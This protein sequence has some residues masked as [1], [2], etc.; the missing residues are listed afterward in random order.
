MLKEVAKYYRALNNS[1]TFFYYSTFSN[2]FVSEPKIGLSYTKKL[3][4]TLLS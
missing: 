4:V 3:C 2:L 1:V